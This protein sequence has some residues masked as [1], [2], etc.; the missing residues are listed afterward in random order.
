LK[1]VIRTRS[2]DIGVIATEPSISYF[3]G[4]IELGDIGLDI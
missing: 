4:A 1:T 3:T 2:A